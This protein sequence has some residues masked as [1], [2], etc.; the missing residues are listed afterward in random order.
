MC[1][2]VN[3][4]SVWEEDQEEY[5]RN[6]NTL[7]SRVFIRLKYNLKTISTSDYLSFPEFLGI[8]VTE[9]ENLIHGRE[10]SSQLI[11]KSFI[12]ETLIESLLC[13]R[14]HIEDTNL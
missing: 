4:E 10:L 7:P 3:K 2:E 11:L 1:T 6:Q 8:I 13:T 9:L 12:Q 14:Y 5:C